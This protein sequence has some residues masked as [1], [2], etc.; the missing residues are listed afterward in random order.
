MAYK[1]EDMEHPVYCLYCGNVLLSGR[2]DRKFCSVACKNHWHNRIKYLSAER[3]QRRVVYI[4]NH[5]Y[6]ILDKLLRLGI[7]TL[8]RSTLVELGYHPEYVTSYRKSGPHNQFTCFD[9]RYEL[10]SSR[11]KKIVRIGL[12]GDADKKDG[13]EAAV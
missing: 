13:E 7:R 5:N 12:E 8:D 1:I 9:I 10:T 2:P 6:S 4:L 3:V 11:I